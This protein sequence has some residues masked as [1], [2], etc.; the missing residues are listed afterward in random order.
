MAEKC[1]GGGQCPFFSLSSLEHKKGD[2]RY[3][4][5]L[6]PFLFI[7]KGK[8]KHLLKMLLTINVELPKEIDRNLI[9]INTRVRTHGLKQ[10]LTE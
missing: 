8:Q 6:C 4:N 3:Q 5:N 2:S 7:Q 9:N 1:Q 10:R